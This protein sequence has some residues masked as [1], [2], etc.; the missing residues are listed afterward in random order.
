MVWE[1]EAVIDALRRVCVCVCGV[2]GWGG[3]REC[4]K[5]G[6]SSLIPSS[7]ERKGLVSKTGRGPPQL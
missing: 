3:D 4:I 2:E 1:R 7:S 5:K 6:S